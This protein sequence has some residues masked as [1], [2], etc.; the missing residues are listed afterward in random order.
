M[1]S[2]NRVLSRCSVRLNVCFCVSRA[3]GCG[4]REE[5]PG[6]DGSHGVVGARLHQP[7]GDTTK[8]RVRLISKKLH[9]KY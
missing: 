1:L 6:T 8:T 4:K 5:H 7:G 9:T 2:V 3:T